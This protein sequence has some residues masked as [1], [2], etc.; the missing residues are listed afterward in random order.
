MPLVNAKCTNCGG[1]LTVD[2]S[3]E[4][5]ICDFCGSPYIVE[6]AIQNYNYYVTQN[7]KADNVNVTAK[8]EAEKERLLHNAETNMGFK[9]YNKAYEIY[10]QVSED[11]PD[12]YRGWHG[13][14]IIATQDFTQFDLSY[15]DYQNVS[16]FVNKEIISTDSFKAEELKAKWEEYSRQY[17]ELIEEKK[18]EKKQLQVHREEL[19]GKETRKEQDLNYHSEAKRKINNIND[20]FVFLGFVFTIIVFYILNKNMN[21]QPSFGLTYILVAAVVLAISTIVSSIIFLALCAGYKS[22]HSKTLD[23]LIAQ[24]NDSISHLNQ[25]INALDYKISYLAQR[26][27]I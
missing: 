14:T 12:D 18:K 8:G 1:T 13:L 26:Y 7:I 19:S 6:K 9:D 3:K 11:Y 23:Q 21:K 2:A 16:S 24:E 5:A 22:K 4:A 17:S 15:K 27:N 10:K 25:E 20:L